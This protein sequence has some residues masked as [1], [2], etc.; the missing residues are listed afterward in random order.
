MLSKRHSV[1]IKSSTPLALKRG[2]LF[3]FFS[4][5]IIA[6][7]HPVAA[8]M[9]TRPFAHNGY[10]RPYL[11]YRPAHLAKD[12]AVVFML[13]GIG[14][15]AMFTSKNFGWKEEADRNGFLVV[16]PNP[17]ATDPSKPA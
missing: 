14:S 13:G 17:V 15:T 9:L 10:D 6:A 2:F 12:P 3:F 5:L 4:T 16:F 11:I 7:L 1:T 8:Q